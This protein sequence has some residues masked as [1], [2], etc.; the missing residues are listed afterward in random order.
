MKFEDVYKD[1]EIAKEWAALLGVTPEKFKEGFEEIFL[2][3]SQHPYPRTFALLMSQTKPKIIQYKS[4]TVLV[5]LDKADQTYN[6]MAKETEPEF[7]QKHFADT[8]KAMADFLEL[9]LSLEATKDNSFMALDIPTL[10]EARDF[11]CSEINK[12]NEMN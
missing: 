4:W 3:K 5:T 12:R 11:A 9:V 6:L 8:P 10:E 7:F 1:E 2:P